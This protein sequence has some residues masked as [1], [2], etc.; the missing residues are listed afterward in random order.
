MY[1]SIPAVPIV[2]WF[3]SNGILNNSETNQTLWGLCKQRNH[4][5][6]GK[7]N[8]SFFFYFSGEI[9]SSRGWGIFLSHLALPWGI[10]TLFWPRGGNSHVFG[11]KC[12][13]PGGWLILYITRLKRKLHHCRKLF[14]AMFS[15][16]HLNRNTIHSFQ[17]SQVFCFT[18]KIKINLNCRNKTW[19]L[20]TMAKCK[21]HSYHSTHF[22][23]F[24]APYN[25]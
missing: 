1:Q 6:T 11:G 3:V 21:H 17:K 10:S 23:L 2:Q 8:C 13:M 18:L 25:G 19:I 22:Q 5:G 20:Q 16:I 24:T 7:K 9:E 14:I 15:V 4:G 12:R